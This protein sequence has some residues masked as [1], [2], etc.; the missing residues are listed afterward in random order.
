MVLLKD[1]LEIQTSLADANH[2]YQAALLAYWTAR[3]DFEK[4]LGEE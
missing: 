4:A 1:V 2:R 3:A